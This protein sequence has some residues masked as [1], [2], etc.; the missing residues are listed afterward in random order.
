MAPHGERPKFKICFLEI[1]SPDKYNIHVRRRLCSQISLSVICF[2]ILPVSE[3]DYCKSNKLISLKL[4]VM[5][6]PIGR[7]D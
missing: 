3:Q 1:V 7:T 4:D 6:Q 2:V 5:I